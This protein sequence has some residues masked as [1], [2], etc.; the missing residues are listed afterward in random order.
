VTLYQ[1][2]RTSDEQHAYLLTGANGFIGGAVASALIAEG[3]G[4]RSLVRDKTKADAVAAHNV[5]AVIGSLDDS[6]QLEAEARLK[7]S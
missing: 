5:D 3:H 6:A 4:V 2:Q 7:L 1:Q